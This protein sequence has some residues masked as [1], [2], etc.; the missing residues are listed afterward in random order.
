MRAFFG[1]IRV[2][3]LMVLVVPVLSLLFVSGE[4][5]YVE[6]ELWRTHEMMVPLSGAAAQSSSILDDL[7]EERARTAAFIGAG[8]AETE[9]A[10]M[11]EQRQ[12]TDENIAKLIDSLR[13]NGVVE[14]MPAMAAAVERLTAQFS[15]L[16]DHRAAVDGK[17]VR[18]PDNATFYAHVIEALIGFVASVVEHNP[19]PELSEHLL[20]YYMLL[21]ATEAADQERTRGSALLRGTSRGLFSMNSFLDYFDR[22]I[23]EQTALKEFEDFATQEQLELFETRMSDPA[24][25]QVEAFREILRDLPVTRDLQGM[26]P[27]AWAEAAKQRIHL[28]RE[29]DH[30]I[31]ERGR[32]TAETELGHILSNAIFLMTLNLIS[33]VIAVVVGFFLAVKVANPIKK[34]STTING[35]ADGDLTLEVPYQEAAGEMG[36]MARAIGAYKEA[37]QENKRLQAQQQ[38]QEEQALKERTQAIQKLCDSIE[39]EIFKAVGQVADQTQEMISVSNDMKSAA[40][41]VQ[42]NSETVATSAGESLRNAETVASATTELSSSISDVSQRTTS[43]ARISDEASQRS[44]ETMK[45]VSG[46]SEAARNIGNV[47][48]VI[49]EIAEQTNLLALN[50]TIEAARAGEAGRGFA[51][52]AGEVKNLANQTQKSTAEIDTQISEIQGIAD[53]AVE[54]MGAI[55]ETITRIND[56]MGDVA[57]SVSQQDQATQEINRSVNESAEGARTVT[58]RISEVST[59]TAGILDL[60]GQV[61]SASG[62][63]D[64]RVQDLRT[65][66]TKIV[67]TAIPEADRREHQRFELGVEGVLKL[68]GRDL[69]VVVHDV[70]AVGV[71]LLIPD[72]AAAGVQVSVG[73][74]AM[75]AITSHLVDTPVQVTKQNERGIVVSITDKAVIE[76]LVQAGRRQSGGKARA[77]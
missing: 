73:E 66:L 30:E 54:S 60:A 42:T 6:V 35:L 44:T 1:S 53:S 62:N 3:V 19:S 74:Q 17:G 57:E 39:N 55:A 12:H 65:T 63:L 48:K 7:Q 49:S 15:L 26:D 14:R 46:L 40:Q 56:S 61:S 67:R 13:E 16:P 59:T 71:G 52:V 10:A 70:N 37:S 21:V 23:T 76:R 47:V 34:L 9:T 24:A 38:E 72:A 8:F 45:I 27:Q 28:L 32:E 22:R 68:K 18:V 5:L 36:E 29:L 77:A 41:T 20:P 33:L 50:A 75:L 25:A 43:T 11:Q 4:Q 69:G 64:D 31:I 51:V 2:K 58:D